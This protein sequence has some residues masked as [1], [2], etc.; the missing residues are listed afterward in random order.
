[1]YQTN[2][3]VFSK[4]KAGPCW[5]RFLNKYGK[6][7]KKNI[8][9]KNNIL[10]PNFSNQ[11]SKMRYAQLVKRNGTHWTNNNFYL[12]TRNRILNNYKKNVKFNYV[13]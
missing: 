11:S 5:A 4:C 3:I 12:N 1:M 8:N 10:A 7:P 6:C 13:C 9:Q 2:N